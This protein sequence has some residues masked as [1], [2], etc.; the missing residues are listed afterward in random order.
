MVTTFYPPHNFGGDG[1][2]VY[3]LANALAQRGHRVE[4][5]YCRDAYEFLNAGRPS[6][7]AECANHPNVTVHALR[8]RARL[9][10]MLMTH[11]TG[12]AGLHASRVREILTGGE[13]DVVHYHNMSL[14]GLSALRFGT[15]IK[16]YTMHDHWLVC[17]LHVL[18]KFDRMPCTQKQCIP[19][20]VHA[21]R[22]PQ[23]WRYTGMPAALLDHVDAFIAL[24][25]FSLAKHREMGL[26]VRA[27]V[28][29]LPH[30]VPA[31]PPPG[32]AADAVAPDPSPFFLVVGRLEKLKGVQVAI[33]AF[34]R[35]P[36]CNLII[37]GDG[38]YRPRLEQDARGLPHVRFRGT[39]GPAAL[40]ELYRRA[41]ALIVP[42]IGYETFGTVI[43]EAFAQRTPAI[44]HNLGALPEVVRQSAGGVTYDDTPGL[45]DAVRRLHEDDALRD[46]LGESGH[47]AYL[48][49]WT[50]EAHLARY[51]EL[52]DQIRAGTSTARPAA[53][54]RR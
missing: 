29:H 18:W 12:Y 25:G 40:Q 35:Y 22:P 44:V 5:V 11:Q 46:A 33:D 31:A 43:V 47:R 26:A 49:Y 42:S 2:Y 38:P 27:P 32:P 23:L 7:S 54:R 34:R 21:G 6:P 53:G 4:V 41:I 15:G 8:S 3:R 39:V 10:S 48:T 17:P 52:I 1:I 24:S 45:C 36:A 16:L 51:F 19:C 20:T 50:A 28:V 14:I 37:A 13:F 30:F 9:L